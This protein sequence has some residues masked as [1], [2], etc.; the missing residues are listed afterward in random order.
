[1]VSQPSIFFSLPG[2]G[3]FM[4]VHLTFIPPGILATVFIKTAVLVADSAA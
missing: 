1:M 2:V 3:T 4:F